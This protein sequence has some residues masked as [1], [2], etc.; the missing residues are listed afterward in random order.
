M[1]LI[2]K[3][4]VYAVV[5][6]IIAVSTLILTSA[7]LGAAATE[8]PWEIIS[9]TEGIVVSRKIIPNSDVF[10]FRGEGDVN[11]PIAKVLSVIRDTSRQGEWV[12][13]VNEIKMIKQL[14]RYDRLEYYR[15]GVPWPLRDRDF[16]YKTSINVDKAQKSILYTSVSVLDS[17]IPIYSDRVRGEIHKITLL[18]SS[19]D[20]G[21][22]T[23]VVGEAHVDP[24]GSIPKWIFNMIQK[25]W[26]ENTFKNVRKQVQ[27]SDIIDDEMAKELN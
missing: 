6:S 24:K 2:K 20:Q 1:S 9:E 7:L 25:K 23:H 5:W 27:K 8:S 14:N 15:I 17:A 18:L 11:A 4:R 21:R 10:A 16:S 3:D 12:D 19:T 26:P 13:R 22:R